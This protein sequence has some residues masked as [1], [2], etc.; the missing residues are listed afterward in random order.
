MLA[1]RAS[2]AVSGNGVGL[3]LM[4]AFYVEEVGYYSLT[5]NERFI[6]NRTIKRF[7]AELRK[8]GFLAD[9]DDDRGL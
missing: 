2:H 7:R 3:E 5:D 4:R 9:R 6:L 8:A 1:E